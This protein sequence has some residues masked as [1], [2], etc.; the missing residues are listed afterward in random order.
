M[1]ILSR[2]Q[3]KGYAQASLSAFSDA[4]QV[5]AWSE[6]H[7]ASLVGQ[8]VVSGSN[9]Q[10]RPQAPVSRAEVAKLLFTLW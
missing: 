2:T 6:T 4:G 8:Q 3:A 9:G 5:P 10:L 1:T 7:V